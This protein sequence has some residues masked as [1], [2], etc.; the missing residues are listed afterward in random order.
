MSKPTCT[1]QAWFCQ[2]QNFCFSS[3]VWCFVV[4]VI[5]AAGCRE[6]KYRLFVVVVFSSLDGQKWFR[7]LCW[8]LVCRILF[9]LIIYDFCSYASCFE[10]RFMSLLKFMTIAFILCSEHTQHTHTQSNNN[11]RFRHVCIGTRQVI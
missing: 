10:T 4:V 3:N 8:L 5:V 7:C 11:S 9:Y 1:I 6:E 2:S